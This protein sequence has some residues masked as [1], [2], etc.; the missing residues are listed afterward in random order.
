[1]HGARA[2]ETRVYRHRRARFRTLHR[3]VGM[4]L[5]RLGNEAE[6]AD[7]RLAKSRSEGIIDVC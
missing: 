1:M 3:H 4:C 2:G 5:E 7:Q 6:E